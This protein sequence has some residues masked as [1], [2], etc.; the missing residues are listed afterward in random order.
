MHS[1]LKQICSITV[2]RLTKI[3]SKAPSTTLQTLNK[4]IKVWHYADAALHYILWIPF[5]PA[6]TS[7][8]PPFSAH[9]IHCACNSS[10]IR[11]V[12]ICMAIGANAFETLS[13]K[14]HQLEGWL[15]TT[16]SIYP[17]IHPYMRTC[18]SSTTPH[19]LLYS[20]RWP[21]R[22]PHPLL[23][24]LIDATEWHNSSTSSL[25]DDNLTRTLM[26]TL[27]AREKK[28]KKYMLR[29]VPS[30]RASERPR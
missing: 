18:S 13:I 16:L 6:W 26:M 20:Y 4:R 24:L 7:A 19:W 3:T 21:E 8:K 15:A 27:Q 9:V 2:F 12:D 22:S 30:V 28:S 5:S 1:L 10:L 25:L 14:C 11:T 23:L 17:S 29:I